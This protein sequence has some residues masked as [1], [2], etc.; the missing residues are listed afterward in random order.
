MEHYTKP[1]SMK[2][3]STW[4][5]ERTAPYSIPRTLTFKMLAVKLAKPFD[6]D[7]A[8]LVVCASMSVGNFRRWAQHLKVVIHVIITE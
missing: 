7:I 2:L 6:T 4:E 8:S 1:L 5:G 3:F